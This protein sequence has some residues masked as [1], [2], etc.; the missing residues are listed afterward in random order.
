MLTK[1]LVAMAAGGAGVGRR[2][3]SLGMAAVGPFPTDQYRQRKRD[4]A[5]CVWVRNENEGR[6]HHREIPVID[7]AI[8][9][10]SVLHKPGLEGAEEED[11][12]HIT[13]AVG[14]GDENENALIDD[15]RPIKQT[16]DAVE[17][18]PRRGDGEGALPRLQS[19]C[20]FIRRD[21]IPRE[22]LLT[23]G[24]FEPRWEETA[25]HLDR[26]DDPDEREKPMHR[27]FAV[28]EQFPS[29]Y[30]FENIDRRHAEKHQRADDHFDVMHRGNAG[31]LVTAHRKIDN[32]FNLYNYVTIN[33]SESQAFCEFF[34]AEIIKCRFFAQTKFKSFWGFEWIF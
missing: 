1:L 27:L 7:A 22:L 26:V 13:N 19:R 10:A 11:A 29:R 9:A 17:G 12:D 4:E 34:A 33:R 8:G 18:E 23:A 3:E 5:I 30:S 25:R 28:E 15:L 2:G 31:Y 6:E 20:F 24:A 21:E 14:E 16:D 32:S